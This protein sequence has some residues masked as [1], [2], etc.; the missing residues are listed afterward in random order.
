MKLRVCNV[1][2]GLVVVEVWEET[3]RLRWSLDDVSFIVSLVK[4]EFKKL[5]NFLSEVV[6]EV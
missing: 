6:K 3:V 5:V 2:E 1:S 4:A